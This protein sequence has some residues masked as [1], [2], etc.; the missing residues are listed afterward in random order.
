MPEW[1]VV[2]R[3]GASKLLFYLVEVLPVLLESPS[4]DVGGSVRAVWTSTRPAQLTL[5]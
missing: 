5:I 3:Q 4:S 2:S 1:G